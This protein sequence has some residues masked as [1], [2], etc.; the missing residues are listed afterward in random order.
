MPDKPEEN[1]QYELPFINESLT[2]DKVQAQVRKKDS[3]Y[4]HVSM[5]IKIAG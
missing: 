4:V 5:L 1:A 2:G 3:Q